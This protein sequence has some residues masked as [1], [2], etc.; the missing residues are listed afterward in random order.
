MRKKQ[1]YNENGIID[2]LNK[3][4]LKPFYDAV[5]DLTDVWF[6]KEEHTELTQKMSEYIISGGVYGNEKNGDAI[7]I[8]RNDGNR[9]KYLFKLA[10]LPYKNM[11]ILYTFLEKYKILLPFC[12]VH[13]FFSKLFGKDRKRIKKKI[14]VINSESENSIINKRDLIKELCLR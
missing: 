14:K 11:C 13:R 3:C 7:E 1:Y 2:L 9:V 12:Y 5:C 6:E 10:F 4:E 8:A